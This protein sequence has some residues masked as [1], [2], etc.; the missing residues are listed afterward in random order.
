MT[1]VWW[2]SSKNWIVSDIISLC[3]VI[4]FIKAFK[5]VCFK[6]ALTSYILM[7]IISVVGAVLTTLLHKQNFVVYFL[8]YVNNPFLLQMSIFTPSYSQN[9]VFI[10]ILSIFLPGLMVSYLRRFDRCRTTNIYLITTV[11]TYFVGSLLWNLINIFS[12]TPI[13]FDLIVQGIMIIAFSLFAFKRKELRTIWEG[14][15]FD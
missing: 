5:F 6:V 11:T 12:N 14:T 10:S 3:M 1:L 9:C 7:N 13:P 2:F 4:S 8:L 15:F